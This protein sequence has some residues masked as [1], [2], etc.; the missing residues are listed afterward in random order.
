MTN[1]TLVTGGAGFVGK[2]LVQKLRAQGER[3][4]SFDLSTSAHDDDVQG[5][6]LDD[7]ALSQAMVGVTSVFHLAGNAQLWSPDETIFAEIN[8]RGTQLVARSA[9]AAGVGRFVHCSSLTTLVGKKTPIGASAANEET[10]LTANEMLGA[11]PR[12]K[13]QAEQV[14]VNAIKDGLDGVIAMPTEPLGPGDESLTPPTQMILDFVNGNTPAYIDCVLN[15]VP[16]GSLADG[17]IAARDRGRKGARYLLGGENLEMSKLLLML[18]TKTGRKMPRMKMP[19][20]V[21]L[22]AGIIDTKIVTALTKKP[23]KA[24]LTGVRL[25]GR[26]VSFSSQKAADDLGWTASAIDPA[27]DDTLAWFDQAGLLKSV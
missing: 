27:L 14:I 25:A 15:F 8:T 11:Y 5:S 18:E 26:Q 9:M 17:L 19:Y 7:D 2:H 4:R 20:F 22:A 6:I 23:P 21:A 13:L 12:S 10:Q 3:V 1:F 24:P 16:V